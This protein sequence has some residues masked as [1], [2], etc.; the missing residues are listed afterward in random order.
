MGGLLVAVAAVGIFAAVS[1]AG[2]GPSTRYVVAARDLRIG[3]ILSTADLR[4]VAIDL[5][6][7]QAARAFRDVGALEGTV[8]VAPVSQGSLVQSSSVGNPSADGVPTV[9]IALPSADA[10]SGSLREGDR[11]DAYVSYGSDTDSS[12]RVVAANAEVVAV[13]SGGDTVSG[14]GQVQVTLA[15]PDNR[16]RLRL[17]NGAHAGKVTLALV[18]GARTEPVKT[19]D[20]YSETELNDERAPTSVPDSSATT[21]P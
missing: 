9:A 3:Q 16:A 2:K 14:S 13:S 17:I 12:T 20:D 4:T 1:G 19:T 18:T 8:V 21:R 15:V 6:A 10:L 7:A 5:P 11:V